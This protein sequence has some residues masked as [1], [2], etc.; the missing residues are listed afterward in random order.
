MAE[1][2]WNKR[3]AQALV[4]HT[5]ILPQIDCAKCFTPEPN[6]PY[7]FETCVKGI[8]RAEIVLAILDGAD[9]DSGTC[10]EAGYA[11][12]KG[13]PVI[14]VRT[15]LRPAEN[16]ANAM[17]SQSCKMLLVG[18]DFDQLVQNILEALEN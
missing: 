8:E 9:A 15:D 16:G 4:G 18:Q 11:Y 3:L 10:W 6:W 1:Q 12:A 7:V 2:E 13:K 14:G 17:L 5:V